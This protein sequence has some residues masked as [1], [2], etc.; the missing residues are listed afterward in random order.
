MAASIDD[1]VFGRMILS[2]Y[3]G[4]NITGEFYQDSDPM[5]LTEEAMA[6]IIIQNV[7]P[8]FSIRNII[9]LNSNHFFII[10]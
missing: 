10:Y 7:V 2:T 9:G 6:K 8:I 4:T 3:C 5:L 1:G